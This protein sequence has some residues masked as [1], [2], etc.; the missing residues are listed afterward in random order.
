MKDKVALAKEPPVGTVEAGNTL[1][2]VFV[3]DIPGQAVGVYTATT[4]PDHPLGSGRNLL[5]GN[6]SPG[7]TFNTFRSYTTM[8]DYTVDGLS[9]A[10]PPFTKVNIRQYATTVPLGV[11]GIRTTYDL[12]GPPDTPDSLII[13]QDVNVIGSTFDNSYIEV[14]V[15]ITNRNNVDTKIGIRYLW[16]PM[17]DNDDGPTFQTVDPI[18]PL[19]TNEAEYNQPGFQAFQ[20]ADND[21]NPNPPTYIIYGTAAGPGNI[22]ITPPTRIEYVYWP[23]GRTTTFDYT[24]NP[25]RNI[26]S[27]PNND[28][29]V[30]LYWG[31]SIETAITLAAKGGSFTS[32]AALFATKPGIVPPFINNHICILANRIF[33]VCRQEVTHTKLLAI[34]SLDCGA[35]LGCEIKQAQCFVCPVDDTDN[36]SNTIQ[37]QVALKI[38]YIIKIKCKVVQVIKP[39]TFTTTAHLPVP[40]NATVNCKVQNATCESRQLEDDLVETTVRA[41]IELQS[42]GTESVVIPFVA[43][44]PVGLCPANPLASKEQDLNLVGDK[45]TASAN[46]GDDIKEE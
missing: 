9:E 25:G 5:F 27:P 14:R 4:G 33:D 23:T 46:A 45:N 43:S 40:E 10:A 30:L 2:K 34:P 22:G 29:A 39:F 41:S 19:V 31:H 44:C 37:V 21:N 8:T 24:I 11:T 13:V 26:S 3:Q 15:H 32:V 16:D 20:L 38:S 42:I 28:S 1:Y 7:T 12:P 35:L 36:S 6:G 17:I 18:G